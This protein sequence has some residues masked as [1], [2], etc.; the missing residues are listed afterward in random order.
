LKRRRFIK[1]NIR[2]LPQEAVFSSKEIDIHFAA[3]APNCSNLGAH[4][5]AAIPLFPYYKA[6]VTTYQH[7]AVSGLKK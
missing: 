5:M 3:K 2:C 6:T 7:K 4:F 1:S